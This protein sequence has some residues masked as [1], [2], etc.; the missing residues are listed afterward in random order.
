MIKFGIGQAVRRVEDRR[1][2]TGQGRYVDDITLPGICHGV[3][4]LSPHA[5]ARIKKVDASKAKAAPGVLLVLTGADAKHDQLGGFTAAM[6]PEDLGAPKG[7]RIYQQ[8]LQSDKARFV[9]DRI[10]FVVAE[11]L[12]QA[13]DAA[14]MVEVDY[15]T[16]PAV[17]L[18]EDAAKDGAPKVW[19]DNPNGNVAFQLM[20]GD[21]AATDAAF[22]KA[23]HHVK[24][25]IENNR[26]APVS[27]EPRA[28]IGDY[29][30][31]ED[32]YTLYT[33]SQ[34]PHGARTEIAH[35]F[36]IAENQLRVVSP[37]VGGGFGL[38]GGAVSGRC[39]CAVGVKEAAS[40]CEVGCDTFR[41][42]DDGSHRPR[43][44]KLWRAGTRRKGQNPRDPLAVALPGGRLFRRPGYGERSILDALYSGSL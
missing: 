5:H 17:A 21:P 9:G 31:A 38:K 43:P 27:M 11:T 41:S 36:H 39:A 34:N 22:A 44:C 29:N 33:S 12:A 18:L 26:L 7:H 6:M 8:L 28:A 25:R 4:V 2:L 32:S 35:I 23:K 16:L 10:A 40:P 1:F 19:D 37:D 24:L 30:M 3:N 14:D 15:E 42:D 13:R 20:I